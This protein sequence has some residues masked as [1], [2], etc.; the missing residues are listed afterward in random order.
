MPVTAK[1]KSERAAAKAVKM[2]TGLASVLGVPGVAQA[3]S[4]AMQSVWIVQPA[5]VPAGDRALASGE[6]VLKQRLLPTGLAELG[7]DAVLGKATLPAG[8]QLVAAIA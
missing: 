6:F 3:Q 8:T 4:R 1:S 7:A 5:A 2:I